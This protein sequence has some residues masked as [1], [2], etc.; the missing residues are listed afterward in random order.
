MK[1]EIPNPRSLMLVLLALLPGAC[2]GPSDPKL[3]LEKFTRDITSE[4][5]DVPRISTTE[6]AE[7]MA[8]SSREQPQLLD[9]REPGEYAVS[10]LSGAVRV[11]PDATAEQ[12]LG[13]IDPARPVVVYCSVGYRSS[14]LAR[15]LISAGSRQT[16]NLEGSIFKWANEDRPL[17]RDDAS[18]RM[19]HPYND[20]YGRLLR[21][22]LRA[23]H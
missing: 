16:M 12:I 4:F 22:E 18:T 21:K 7:W 13:R 19:V 11:A 5:D 8:D 15:R 1:L 3:E 9:A 2:N 10:H 17:V 6:L 23:Y 14:I 20:R